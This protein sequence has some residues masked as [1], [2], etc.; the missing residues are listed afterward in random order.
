MVKSWAKDFVDLFETEF[1]HKINWDEVK[2]KRELCN[3]WIWYDEERD[4]WRYSYGA[5][6]FPKTEYHHT[7]LCEIQFIKT[8][9]GLVKTKK[10]YKT[11]RM[12]GQTGRAGGEKIKRG[13]WE[14]NGF[15]TTYI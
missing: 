13:E 1:S 5:N 9:I 3:G 4:G 12:W 2:G 15:R 14:Y 6:Y 8:N 10:E 11:Y 7:D